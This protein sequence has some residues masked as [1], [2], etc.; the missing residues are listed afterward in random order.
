MFNAVN[1]TAIVLIAVACMAS[2]S[3]ESPDKKAAEQL[4]TQINNEYSAGNYSRA[5]ALMDTLDT[6]YHDQLDA[7][8]AVTAL[9]PQAIEKVTVER[10]AEADNM[11]ATA[12]AEIENL[13]PLMKHIS[14]DDLEGYYVVAAA[15]DPAF[16]NRN[17]VEPRV[18]DAD[19]RFYVVAQSRSKKIGL[20]QV[21]LNSTSDQVQ[22]SVIPASSER[23]MSVEGSEMASFLPEEADTLGRWATE[24]T[25]NSATL[26]G[27]KSH[28]ALKLSQKQAESFATAW[29]FANAKQRLRS[30]LMLREKL[31][32]QLQTARDHIANTAEQGTK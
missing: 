1:K 24:H 16:I 18:N 4:L 3:S 21:A 23:V 5:L 10:I 9:R 29:R 20:N 30:A 12:T 22:T 11:I 26:L 7:R 32:R 14:G 25:V 19:F 8:R 2:C 13:S 17:G 27:S 28:V 31:D 6:R 15:Y